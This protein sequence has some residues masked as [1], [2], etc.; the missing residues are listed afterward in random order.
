[1]VVGDS[2]SLLITLRRFNSLAD[3][4]CQPSGRYTRELSAWLGSIPSNPDERRRS[5]KPISKAC[6]TPVDC[7]AM[8]TIR[9]LFADSDDAVVVSTGMYDGMYVCNYTCMYV[10]MYV[11]K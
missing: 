1:M 11:S 2:T 3:I 9:G 6:S 7:L 10:C 5:M 4:L 8:L